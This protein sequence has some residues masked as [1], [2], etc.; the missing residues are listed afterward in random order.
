MAQPFVE[1][2]F[3]KGKEVFKSILKNKDRKFLKRTSN[4]IINWDRM[5]FS[6]NIIHIHGD[7]DHTIPLK[8]VKAGYIIANGSHMMVYN[9]SEEISKLIEICINSGSAK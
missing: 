4:I 3:K 6:K 2:D 7:K 9:R 1:P 8:N 5:A